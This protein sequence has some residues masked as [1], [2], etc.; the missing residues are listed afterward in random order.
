MFW[1][2]NK[3]INFYSTHSYLEAWPE[4]DLSMFN[5]N[6]ILLMSL[7]KMSIQQ[8]HALPSMQRVNNCTYC[9]EVFVKQDLLNTRFT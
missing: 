1:L 9:L 8:K 6:G 3:K 2:S 4:L 7:K 5:T